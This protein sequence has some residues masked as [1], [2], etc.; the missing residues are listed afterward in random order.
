MRYLPLIL[1]CPKRGYWLMSLLSRRFITYTS[2]DYTQMHN[3]HKQRNDDEESRCFGNNLITTGRR[4]DSFTRRTIA[5]VADS[6][7]LEPSSLWAGSL[8]K[9]L[10]PPLL[11][12]SLSLVCTCC[13]EKCTGTP[14][15]QPLADIPW[16]LFEGWHAP[17]VEQLEQRQQQTLRFSL[18]LAGARRIGL[19]SEI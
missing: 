13:W 5:S 12:L 1:Y 3:T 7:L 8:S 17:P 9:R 2:E 16:G 10:T 19:K 15:P 6:V 4:A 18:A 14:E 11:S